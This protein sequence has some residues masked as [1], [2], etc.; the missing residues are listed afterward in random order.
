[1]EAKKFAI[2]KATQAEHGQFSLCSAAMLKFSETLVRL[3][4]QPPPPTPLPQQYLSK[5]KQHLNMKSLAERRLTFEK[6]PSSIRI[7]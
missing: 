3:V 4:Y 1:M 6:W 7:V 5:D 2:F